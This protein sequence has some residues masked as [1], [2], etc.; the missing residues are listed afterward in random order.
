[1]AEETLPA[2]RPPLL[3][4]DALRSL[5]VPIVAAGV[6]AVAVSRE[7]IVETPLDPLA[8]VLRAVALGL[9]V[10]AVLAMR[11]LFRRARVWSRASRYAL[12]L[13]DERLLYRR[14]GGELAVAKD[15]VIAVLERGHWGERDGRRRWSDVYVVRA[16]GADPPWLSL[17]PLFDRSP[18]ELAERLMRWRG[19]L[20]AP[21]TPSY[22]APS[23]LA[24]KV[25][26]DAAAGVVPDGGVVI[27]HG[28]GWLARG[29]YATVLLGV[30]IAE[31]YARVGPAGWEQLGIALPTA[32]GLA[33]LAV[34][35]VWVLLT[36]RA[37]APRHGVALVITPAEII[38]R[39]R[40]G[41]LR[42]TFRGLARVRIERKA[43]WSVVEG[44][45]QAR[46]LVIER[47]QDEPIRYDEAFLG[48][49]AEVVVSL[50]EA[51]RKGVIPRPGGHAEPGGPD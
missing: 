3:D 35:L 29:P 41:V 19:P 37:V 46:T 48:A 49:P 16:P 45:H 40:A 34:P 21:E 4:R 36:R 25:Y 10:R 12:V 26:D 8:L 44:Y 14:P 43:S 2:N 39:T 18:G 42:A 6:W 1:M 5:S 24:S 9:T 23:R 38:M 51:Y 32:V 7:A 47:K 15:D 28:R 30:A 33:L 22:P 11:A 31:G 17:P 20:P 13:G 27:R 50:A